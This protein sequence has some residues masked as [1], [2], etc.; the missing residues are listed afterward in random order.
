MLVSRDNQ[1]QWVTS[2]RLS[3]TRIFQ[4]LSNTSRVKRIGLGTGITHT[5]SI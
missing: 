3:P 4:V 1:I 2:T 5:R